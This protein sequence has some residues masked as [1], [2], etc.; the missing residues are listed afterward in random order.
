MLE[1]IVENSFN[2]SKKNRHPGQGSRESPRQVEPKKCIPR[3]IIIKTAKVKTRGNLKS[4]KRKPT[5]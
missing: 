4:S 2:P 1:I 5:S 3:H